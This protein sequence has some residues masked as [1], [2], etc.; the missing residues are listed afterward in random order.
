MLKTILLV[1]DESPYGETALEL[2]LRWAR[3]CD[4]M[5]VGLG[6][7]D[8]SAPALAEA[9]V[10]ASP[11]EDDAAAARRR[12]E[13][14]LGRF[15]VCCAEAGVACKVLEGEGP[16]WE[17]IVRESQ[18]YDLVLLG[19]KS[20]FH[21]PE[22][23]AADTTL[24]QVLRHGGRP[25]VT[26]PEVLGGRGVLV[27]YDGSVAAVRAV[28]ALQASGLDLGEEVHVVTAGRTFAEA[29]RTTGRAVEFLG[30][31][32]IKASP[33]PVASAAPPADVLMNEVRRLD[34]RLV[35]MGACG[36]AR[37][38]QFLFGSTTRALLRTSPAPVLLSP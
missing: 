11:W 34:P 6:V 5:L 29:A 13:S 37:W 16:P 4:A 20:D 14:A 10:L 32:D 26:A 19:K 21:P 2:G 22:R 9:A 36:R 23:E 7:I 8:R 35:V 30:H 33:V 27:A 15:S 1:L 24:Q 12:V 38:R 28:Q 31:H 3:R 18:R 25:V 17:Q